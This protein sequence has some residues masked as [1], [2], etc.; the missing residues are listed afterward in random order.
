MSAGQGG[1]RLWILG[2]V[3]AL[4]FGGAVTAAVVLRG[5]TAPPPRATGFEKKT[6]PHFDHAPV[7]AARYDSPQ[8]VTRDCLRCHADA[9]LVM[10]T[11]HW[12]WVGDE[13]EI[14][15][16]PGK[17]RIGKKNVLNNFCIS[18]RGNEPG[19]TKCHAGYGWADESFDFTK[20]DNVDC[21][22]CHERT[23]TYV[24]GKAGLP[25]KNSDLV[26]AARSVGTPRRE[27]CLTCHAYGGGGQ[28]VKHGDLDSSLNHPLAEEDVHMGRL[29]F[30]CVD[31]H[32]GPNHQIKGRAFSVSVED[33][34]GVGCTDCHPKPEHKDA[35]L[36]AHLRSVACQTCHIP[37]YAGQL[38]TK[39]YWDW[40]KAGDPTR[41]DDPHSYLKIKGEFV[42]E[43]DALPVYTWFNGSV[44][45]YLL[46]DR[47][48]DPAKPTVLNPPM[49][50][51]ADAKAKIWPFKV[52]RAKQPYDAGNR[53]LFPPVTAGKGGYWT[54]FNWDKAFQLGAVASKIAYSGKVGFA[55]T[56][57]YWPLSHMVA[58][59]EKALACTDCHGQGSA[60]LDWK[61]LGY[62][63][64]PLTTGGRR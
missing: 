49:G 16:H 61:Q 5:P 7:I 62:A 38:P 26:A 14:A 13:V 2:A 21:L 8:A 55:E 42:Y 37:S 30:Q 36:N 20:S 19:C 54:E 39:A 22:V 60:R 6:R 29:G 23:G 46:G 63:G 56:E 3:I 41:K 58:P 17:H 47:I 64:D 48:E 32:A 28:A 33:A 4:G 18:I 35:R 11:P 40:S 15:G 27:N 43:Q 34:H 12:L 52:H 50:G 24:K 59:K 57:M 44:G 10:K 45:R 53:Y 9:A 31:C 1:P 25:D 51:I